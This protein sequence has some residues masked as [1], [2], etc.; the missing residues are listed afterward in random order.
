VTAKLVDITSYRTWAGA[1]VGSVPDSL[2]QQSLDEA[3]SGL[4]ADV[5]CGTVDAIVVNLDANAVAVGEVQRRTNNLLAKRNSP[6]GV[7]G[8]GD[9]GVISIPSTPAGSMASVRQIKQHLGIPL[10]VAL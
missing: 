2:I 7:A 6:E 4:V 8:V 10:V 1:S 9:M 3:E 5:G